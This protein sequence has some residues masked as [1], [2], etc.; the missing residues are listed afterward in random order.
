MKRLLVPIG[1]FL[2]I[3]VLGLLFLPRDTI[4]PHRAQPGA[5]SSIT[6][7]PLPDSTINT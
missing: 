2:V 5:T 3:A 4:Q 7:V 1:L 6:P